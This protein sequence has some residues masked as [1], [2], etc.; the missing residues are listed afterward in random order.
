LL[1]F[2]F[3]LKP[4]FNRAQ[5]IVLGAFTSGGLVYFFI[6]LKEF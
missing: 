1:L 5:N 4:D 6:I 2:F 3:F